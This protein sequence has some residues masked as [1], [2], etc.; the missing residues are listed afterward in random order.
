MTKLFS[1]A[2]LMLVSLTPFELT[3]SGATA[4]TT[5]LGVEGTANATPWVSASRSFIVVVWGASV[6]GKTDVFLAVSRDSG[7]TFG[8]PV[9]VNATAGDARLGGE[10]P[11]RVVLVPRKGDPEIVVLWTAR[12]LT[13]QVRMARSRD[14]GRTF[15]APTTLHAPDAVGDRGWPAL[16]ADAQGTA[17]A[18]W[19]DHRGLAKGANQ[20]GVHDHKK[21]A[22]YDGVAMAQRSGLYY[23]RAGSSASRERELTPGVCYCCKTALALAS[24]GT[25]YAAWRHVYPG[26]IRDIAMTVSRDEGRTFAP[27]VRI[28]ED[29]WQLNGCPDDG[30]AMAVDRSG[31]VH[32]VWPTVIGGSMP[33]GA[34]FYATT[35][36]G[37]RFTPRVRVATLGS[38]KPSHPQ[39]VVDV[40]GQVTVAWDELING[41]RVAAARR[42]SHADSAP[43]GAAAPLV[44]AGAESAMYP[45]L[46]ET[47]DGLVAVW[48]AG[49]PSKSVIGIRTLKAPDWK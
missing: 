12:S 48:T 3:S 43:S 31:T 37:Q 35:R 24:D 15:A 34:L 16:A 9:K 2:A 19:L 23:A 6:D 4:A 18:I 28:S 13:T 14:G 21:T 47:T 29:K 25:L 22:E 46:A 41:K 45:V 17:H 32:V 10:L 27:P 39:I 30:P 20:S 36:D 49:L 40:R 5:T 1:I 44:L 42:L 8:E 33:E 7:A 11:P 26:N 38:P